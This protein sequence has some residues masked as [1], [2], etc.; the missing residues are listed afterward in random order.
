[1]E[2]SD[3]GPKSLPITSF[4]EAAQVPALELDMAVAVA[5]V[6]VAVVAPQVAKTWTGAHKLRRQRAKVANHRV[7]EVTMTLITAAGRMTSFH[8]EGLFSSGSPTNSFG[9]RRSIRKNDRWGSAG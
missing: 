6:A 7:A 1:M 4:W 8:S 5:V 2:T 9:W 3:T